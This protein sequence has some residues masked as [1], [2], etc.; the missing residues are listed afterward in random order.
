MEQIAEIANVYHDFLMDAN[1]EDEKAVSAI[2]LLY[3]EVDQTKIRTELLH[4]R[5]FALHY[6][7]FKRIEDQSI[8]ELIF[9]EV[10]TQTFKNVWRWDI[11]SKNRSILVAKE[12]TNHTN[13]SNYNSE[14]EKLE[15]IG[16]LFSERLLD[17]HSEPIIQLGKRVS[18][19]NLAF[20]N[21]TLDFAKENGMSFISYF[22]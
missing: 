14:E 16:Q 19:R 22:F 7:L 8:A 9:Q 2:E 6:I 12:Y 20:V 5:Q 17:K 18:M 4:L 1:N 21:T 3:S 13:S 10:H 11:D 15:A